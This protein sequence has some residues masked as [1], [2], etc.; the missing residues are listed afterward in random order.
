MP[1]QTGESYSGNDFVKRTNHSPCCLRFP[2]TEWRTLK[3]YWMRLESTER[4]SMRRRGLSVSAYSTLHRSIN[5]A[6][7]APQWWHSLQVTLDKSISRIL[8]EE[9]TLDRIHWF[10]NTIC[11]VRVYGNIHLAIQNATQSITSPI[12]LKERSVN[13]FHH[14][15]DKNLLGCVWRLKPLLISLLVVPSNQKDWL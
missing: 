12:V 6:L 4:V 1:S 2:S 15:P 5:Q 10:L 9:R 13:C 3:K 8:T 14:G 7:H 11:T